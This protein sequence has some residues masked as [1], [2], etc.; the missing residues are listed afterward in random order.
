[1][2]TNS[3]YELPKLKKAIKT[4]RPSIR[5]LKKYLRDN[6]DQEFVCR[7]PV[8]CPVARYVNTLLHD[9]CYDLKIGY[10]TS[11]PSSIVYIH[12]LGEYIDE[13]IDF[14]IPLSQALVNFVNKFD[15]AYQLRGK[16]TGDKIILDN[17]V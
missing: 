2:S 8:F 1:M 16:V 17:L 4:I 14:E 10:F 11:L 6:K 12:P 7:N 15:S 13:S 5:G 9:K 3:T